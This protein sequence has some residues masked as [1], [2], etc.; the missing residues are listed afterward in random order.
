MTFTAARVKQEIAKEG[1]LPFSLFFA[2]SYTSPWAW[3]R[4]RF[5][6]LKVRHQVSDHLEQTP[7]PA[8]GLHWLTSIFLLAITS[9]LQPPESY[10][11]LVSLYSYVIIVGFGMPF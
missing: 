11:F 6:S 5:S 7:I 9:M 4:S 1:I 10:N 8:L 2:T 3:L